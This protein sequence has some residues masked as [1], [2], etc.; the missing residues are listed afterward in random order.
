MSRATTPVDTGKPIQLRLDETYGT[1]GTDS[2][3]AWPTDA[4]AV[5]VVSTG[6]RVVKRLEAKPKV[7]IHEPQ[8]A[9]K[10]E[11]LYPHVFDETAGP[12]AIALRLLARA[13]DDAQNGADAYSDGDIGALSTSLGLVATAMAAAHSHT[14]FNESF[15]AVVSHIRRATL[16]ADVTNVSLPQ[17]VVLVKVLRELLQNPMIGLDSA[18]GLVDEL[19]DADWQGE[20]TEVHEFISAL[21]SPAEHTQATPLSVADKAGA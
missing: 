5:G 11:D 12:A 7:E 17:M 3:N 4:A 2:K 16:R 15:G 13:K 18:A 9:A 10:A 20:Q 21:F 6:A 14:G 8:R 1:T 19:A